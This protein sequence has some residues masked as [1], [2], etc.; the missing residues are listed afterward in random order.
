V[1]DVSPTTRGVDYTQRL[2]RKTG[3]GWKRLLNV[4]APYRWNVRR[5]NLGFTLDVGCGIGRNLAH[6]DGNGVGVDHN[7][8]SIEAC[9]EIGLT[10]FTT[11][12]FYKSEYAKPDRFDSLLSAHVVEHV[13]AEQAVEIFTPYLP[14]VKSGGALVFIT[15]QER[16]FASDATHIRFAGF[17][18]VRQL[19]DELGLEVRKQYS[20]P[21]P[22]V[23]GKIFTYNEFITVAGKR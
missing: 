20:F 1:S 9:R 2:Q 14:F 4:Q 22:R 21:F 5:L 13:T 17:P 6:L 7:A 16:G 19:C 23:A 11:E 8:T 15:P 18:E 10:A 3:R 12:E